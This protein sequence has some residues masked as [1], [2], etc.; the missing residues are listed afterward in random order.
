[1]QLR[2]LVFLLFMCV[3]SLTYQ[4]YISDAGLKRNKAL[5]AELSSVESVN[6]SL[7]ARSR[8]VLDDINALKKENNALE[9][10]AR[11]DLGMIKKNEAYYQFVEDDSP[12]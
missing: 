2:L 1:M 6:A 4:L 10:R 11:T 5:S 12:R 3:L 8:K 9:A 7:K